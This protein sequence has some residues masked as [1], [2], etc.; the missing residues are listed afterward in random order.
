MS[1]VPVIERIALEIKSRLDELASGF[2]S[3]SPV[4]EVIRP[5][6]NGTW[7]PKHQQIV[8]TQ[9]GSARSLENDAFG[10]PL[11][12]AWA[13]TFNIRCHIMPSELATET[14]DELA[15]YMWAGVVRVLTQDA[16]DWQ[17]F[18]GI[19]INAVWIDIDPIVHDGSF[20]ALNIPLD[21]IW[22]HNEN[23][24]YQERA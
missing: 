22:R 14:L 10:S 8:L 9:G 20:A 5:T 2:D 12:L 18:G 23:D 3:R 11:A 4:S 24:P 19:A 1:D 16:G 15:N 13:T 21:V 17:T 7:S 6:R